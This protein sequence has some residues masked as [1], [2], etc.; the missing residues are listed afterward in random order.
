MPNFCQELHYR[1][2][3]GILGGY[4]DVD[5][6]C[7]TLVRCPRRARKGPAEVRDIVIVPHGLCGD[8]GVGV[9]TNVGNFLC[10]T[11]SSVRRHGCEYCTRVGDKCDRNS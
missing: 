4:L 11:A 8:L 6:V 5:F 10:N 1:R 7:A 2:P 3:E 9:C